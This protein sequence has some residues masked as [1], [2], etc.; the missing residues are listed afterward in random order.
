MSKSYI[1]FWKNLVSWE[2][3]KTL[4][5]EKIVFAEFV[6]YIC[7]LTNRFYKYKDFWKALLIFGTW[8]NSQILLWKHSGC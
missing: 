1:V 7:F 5:L 2:K 6:N 3:K 8:K 4:S